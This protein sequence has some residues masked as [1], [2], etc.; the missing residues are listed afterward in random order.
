MMGRALAAALLGSATAKPKRRPLLHFYVIKR[1]FVEQEFIQPLFA[2]LLFGCLLGTVVV[3]Y[4]GGLPGMNRDTMYIFMKCFMLD[5][6]NLSNLLNYC[7]KRS[8][9]LEDY[10]L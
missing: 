6:P 10:Y 3:H 8:Q 1:H 5:Y 7:F 9:H 4:K 2:G